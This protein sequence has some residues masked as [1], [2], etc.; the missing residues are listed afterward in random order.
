MW[1]TGAM[2]LWCLRATATPCLDQS[3]AANVR[4][5]QQI[6]SQTAQQLPSSPAPGMTARMQ[7]LLGKV[8]QRAQQSLLLRRDCP[9]QVPDLVLLMLSEETGAQ[10]GNEPGNGSLRLQVAAYSRLIQ[11]CGSLG[12]RCTLATALPQ[13][14][15][16]LHAESKPPLLAPVLM[17]VPDAS[18]PDLQQAQLDVLIKVHGT[19]SLPHLTQDAKL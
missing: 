7:Q 5:L 3:A 1:D 4:L 19:L 16:Q 9:A 15:Q 11:L 2:R 17:S 10:A 18:V 6:A 14:W 12:V 13:A 8:R